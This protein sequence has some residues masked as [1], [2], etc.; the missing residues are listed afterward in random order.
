MSKTSKPLYGTSKDAY[1][2]RVI[3]SEPGLGAAASERI[4]RRLSAEVVQV[5]V[6]TGAD[7]SVTEAVN[8]LQEQALDAAA[9]QEAVSL[10]ALADNAPSQ[11]CN[12][13]NA[14][15][16]LTEFDPFTPNIV[17]VVRRD[18]RDRALAALAAI[19]RVDNLRRLARE[20]QLS[21][22]AALETAPEIRAAIVVAAERRIA[23]RRAAAG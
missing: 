14:S 3:R 11:S 9:A 18:G 8:P 1:F 10:D 23:N 4:L 7:V 5:R 15:N 20:Q 17:V 2:K 22:D 13:S 12:A 19:D 6:R 21:I 16:A